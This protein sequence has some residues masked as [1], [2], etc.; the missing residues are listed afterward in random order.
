MAVS[1]PDSAQI[2][3]V[4]DS[5]AANQGIEA[6]QGRALSVAGGRLTYADQKKQPYLYSWGEP[7][8]L[9]KSQCHGLLFVQAE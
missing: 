1:L 7:K 5:G 8:S 6:K 2:R 4:Q 9:L 3:L